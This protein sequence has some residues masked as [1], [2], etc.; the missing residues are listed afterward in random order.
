[1]NAIYSTNEGSVQ[2]T[3][4]KKRQRAGNV[5]NASN[6]YTN[7]DGRSS[8]TYGM[9]PLASIFS[10]L[11]N[12]SEKPKEKQPLTVACV[13]IDDSDDNTSEEEKSSS[14]CS[15]QPPTSQSYSPK[16]RQ[17]KL[18]RAAG[19]SGLVLL[20]SNRINGCNGSHRPPP[21][22]LCLASANAKGVCS[23]A[24]APASNGDIIGPI[25]RGVKEEELWID[26]Y[27]PR[28]MDELVVHRKKVRIEVIIGYCGGISSLPFYVLCAVPFITRLRRFDHGSWRLLNYRKV[29]GRNLPPTNCWHW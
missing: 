1:M 27:A 23:D 2:K 3:H 26:K 6:R 12:S 13:V 19:G 10:S 11:R 18:N 7:D 17:S 22:Q 5:V 16:P 29:D 9:R 4:K 25:S 24:S 15:S 20:S 14:N 8:N 21:I 28:K